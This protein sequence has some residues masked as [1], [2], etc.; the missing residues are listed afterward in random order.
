[1]RNFIANERTKMLLPKSIDGLSIVPGNSSC[2][3]YSIALNI[4]SDDNVT[5]VVHDRYEISTQFGTEFLVGTF[6]LFLTVSVLVVLGVRLHEYYAKA[7][8]TNFDNKKKNKDE[9]LSRAA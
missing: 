7:T 8:Y 9:F 1:M 2:V 6:F 3:I 5:D 4:P